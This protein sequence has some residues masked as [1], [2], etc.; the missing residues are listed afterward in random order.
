MSNSSSTE[1]LSNL[2]FLSKIKQDQKINIR[3]M[4]IQDNNWSTTISRT[5][6]NVDNR[7][8]TLH[9]IQGLIR[10]S[11]STCK[12]LVNSQNRSDSI[13][14]QNL[15]RAILNSRIGISNL[16]YTYQDDIHF[17]CTLDTIIENITVQISEFQENEDFILE[18]DID[19]VQST[20]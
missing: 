17:A 5:L 10:N 20:I 19:D 18:E 9:F 1:L 6:Y 14:V 4:F 13:M 11:F 7:K 16:K 2:K 15:L 3:D 8:N 12:S